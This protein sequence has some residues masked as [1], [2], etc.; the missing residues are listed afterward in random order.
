MTID[1]QKG[2]TTGLDNKVVS[3]V[4]GGLNILSN[5]LTMPLD[6]SPKLQNMKITQAGT[7]QR[8]KGTQALSQ[9]TTVSPYGVTYIPYT[10]R[11][12]VRI[13]L[14][15]E[16]TALKV[17]T[18]SQYKLNAQQTASR[19][20]ADMT[21]N[22]VWSTGAANVRVDHV[23][24]S[25]PTTRILMASGINTVIQA[26]ICQG[27][28]TS[29]ISIGVGGTVATGD[30]RF[31]G[32]V[33][34]NVMLFRD[35]ELVP[36][37]EWTINSTTGV[38]TVLPTT[39]RFGTYAFDVVRISWQWWTEAMRLL[40]KQINREVAQFQISSPT[41]LTVAI[42]TDLMYDIEYLGV[43]N[44]PINAY[45]DNNPLTPYTPSNSTTTSTNYVFTQGAAYV[46]GATPTPGYT[47]M[48]FGA[49]TG[50]L[51]QPARRVILYRHYRIP[52]RGYAGIPANKVC[53]FDTGRSW[54]LNAGWGSQFVA[55]PSGTEA[56]P[57]F[58]LV[59]FADYN[60]I[61]NVLRTP[62]AGTQ[63]ATWIRFD[64]T[65]NNR[66]VATESVAV[67]SLNTV[68]NDNLGIVGSA[69]STTPINSSSDFLNVGG[70]YPIYG[71]FEVADFGKRSFPRTLSLYAGRLA[72]GGFPDAPMRVALSNTLDSATAG[73]FY[74]NFQT[75]LEPISD[76]N[77][78]S[79]ELAGNADD[80]VSALADFQN[81]LF[82]FCKKGIYRVSAG[83]NSAS[84]T[85][86]AFSLSFVASIGCVNA[87]SV[88]RVDKTIY[89]L[90]QS[91]VYDIVPTIQAGDFTAGEK[92]L[93]IKG[94][95]NNT[96]S[97][98]TEAAS[99]MLYDPILQ[100]VY[101]SVPE[102]PVSNTTVN[103]CGKLYLYNI[104][105]DAWSEFTYGY[106][107][108][109]A[110]VGGAV[111]LNGSSKG[112]D[113]IVWTIPGST[114]GSTSQIIP[115]LLDQDHC[116]DGAWITQIGSSSLGTLA[117]S[118]T[119]TPA[120]KFSQESTVT[121]VDQSVYSFRENFSIKLFPLEDVVDCTVT[122]GGTNLVYGEQWTKTPY[123]EI[124]LLKSFAFNTLD[125][126]KVTPDGKRNYVAY[127]DRLPKNIGT[128]FTITIGFPSTTISWITSLPTAS[129]VMTG[130]LYE[131]W[132]Y[133]PMMFSD[134][135]F[136][137]KRI[138]KYIGYYKN[139]EIQPTY[140][141]NTFNN[142]SAGQD[143]TSII[144]LPRLRGDVSVAFSYF[145]KGSGYVSSDLYGLKDLFWD[146][147]L[148]DVTPSAL[149]Q[150]DNTRI[151]ENILGSSYGIQ[152]IN[153]CRSDGF[154]E[155]AGFELQAKQGGKNSRHW[156]S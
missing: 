35:G 18:L 14:A 141:N 123:N 112:R 28:T 119:A 96:S 13:V 106:S 102:Q 93:K 40:G 9:L 115:L 19:L 116:I 99:W 24:T 44:Y 151:V 33:A 150:S 22:N 135:L 146:N 32:A 136:Q 58:A 117:A 31:I 37:V 30:T 131:S 109:W 91:G 86:T 82:I 75:L 70:A 3:S 71:F 156:S 124:V 8:R 94:A 139:T 29:N 108:R 56:A 26:S 83:G 50:A 49:F 46:A 6:D 144:N 126:E 128:D 12:G 107:G 98:L 38:I 122:V 129:V 41:D 101:V 95:F 55:P 132:H 111:L 45:S 21:F 127:V 103:G 51:P 11:N 145:D 34:A 148:T 88:I 36:R 2:D 23:I 4:S 78:L 65:N 149:Q 137:D 153:F 142:D 39:T 61:N 143:V 155:L 147:A 74:N 69:A 43:G 80:A 42:P 121:S 120:F 16:S 25:E 118:D 20:I 64:S 138:I 87:Q 97:T 53:V 77:S 17:Y 133:T 1:R 154:F 92:S 48:A 110:N 57:T 59:Q 5:P 100:E 60:S 105:R 113:V 27:S 54:S 130:M 152:V 81:S 140:F 89:F 63:N 66:I 62:A 84:V 85:P 125:V 7:V 72:I 114:S 68:A 76:D 67:V 104:L 52:F 73:T 10:L 15:K 47:H 79:F 90:S 134:L